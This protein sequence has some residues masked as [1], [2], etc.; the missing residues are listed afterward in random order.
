MHSKKIA[1]AAVVMVLLVC[2]IAY[3]FKGGPFRAAAGQAD[4]DA[5]PVKTIQASF[6]CDPYNVRELVGMVDYVFVG[7]VTGRDETLYKNVVL[8][9]DENGELKEVGAP[10]TPYTIQVRSNIKGNLRTD[11]PIPVLKHGGVTQDQ[12]AIFLYEDDLLPREGQSYI[13]LAFAQSDGSLL[14]SGPNSNL[15]LENASQ[16]VSSGG[17]DAPSPLYDSYVDAYENEVIPINRERFH[18]TYEG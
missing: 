14:V 17:D 8:M 16:A 7:E 15:P 18:S 5:L 10:Y 1:A 6:V 9:E 13:F 3:A 4:V 11:T 2:V 12:A